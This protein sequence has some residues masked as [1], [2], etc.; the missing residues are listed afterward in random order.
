MEQ[1]KK[2]LLNTETSNPYQS[3]LYGQP[4]NKGY[5][6]IGCDSYE[7]VKEL[8]YGNIE[9]E[10]FKKYGKIGLHERLDEIADIIIETLCSTKGTINITGEEYPTRLVKDKMLKIT[11]SHIEYVFDCLDKNTTYVRNIKQY[12]LATLFNAPSTINSYYTALVNHD[13]YSPNR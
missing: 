11:S 1:S 13:L 2:D 7:K 12:L 8:V 9:Y 4:P 5:D 10:H 6:E 3:Y